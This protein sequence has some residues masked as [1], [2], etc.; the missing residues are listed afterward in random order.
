MSCAKTN[1]VE[2]KVGNID[3]VWGWDDWKDRFVTKMGST[4]GVDGVHQKY[5]I[6]KINT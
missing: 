2:I 4:T 3:V 6:H 1:P 5:I